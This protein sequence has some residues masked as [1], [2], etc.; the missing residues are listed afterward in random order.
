MSEDVT[1]DPRAEAR[2]RRRQTVRLVMIGILVI[3]AAALALDNLRDVTIGW[4]IGDADAPLVI[5]LAV[6]F[7]L[8]LAIGWLTGR[9]DRQESS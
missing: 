8:G 1:I 6:A 3:V 4:V 7:L 2:I 9:Q 5:V